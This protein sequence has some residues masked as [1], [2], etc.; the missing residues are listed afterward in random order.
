M[1]LRTSPELRRGGSTTGLGQN[2]SHA[3]TDTTSSFKKGHN[4]RN[5]QHAH[6]RTTA[7]T[8]AAGPST[9]AHPHCA[10]SL[11][12]MQHAARPSAPKTPVAQEARAVPILCI[13]EGA[14]SQK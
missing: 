6:H 3:P 2:I 11:H 1:V 4:T 5:V 12:D 9:L 14:C 13:A 10:Q 7:A 8:S